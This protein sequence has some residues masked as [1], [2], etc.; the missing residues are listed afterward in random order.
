MLSHYY[1][2]VS[3]LERTV[4]EHT[5]S[6]IFGQRTKEQNIKRFNLYVA[7]LS[8]KRGVSC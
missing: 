3:N 5:I 2:M 7:K 4:Q 6:Y 8:R 1:I